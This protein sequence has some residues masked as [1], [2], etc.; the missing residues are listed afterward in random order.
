MG[1]HTHPCRN[2]RLGCAQ[3]VPCDGPMERNHDGF[4][5]VVCAWLESWSEGPQCEACES[6]DDCED[7]G[8]PAHLGHAR[9]CDSPE[10]QAKRD[11][12]GPADDGE[13]WSGGFAANH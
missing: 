3:T 10:A 2:K 5:E 7:C 6:G 13:A 1:K 11:E 9:G 12:D 4:P 8:M